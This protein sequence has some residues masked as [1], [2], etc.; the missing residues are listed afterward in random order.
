MDMPL[1]FCYLLSILATSLLIGGSMTEFFLYRLREKYR[2]ANSESDSDG[3]T[4]TEEEEEE[5]YTEKYQE[6]YEALATRELS[7]A[8]LKNL[9]TKIVREEVAAKV[10]VLLTY[11]N[12]TDTFWYYTDKLSEVSYDILETVARKFV[13]DNDCKAIFLTPTEEP[14]KDAP[15]A[16]TADP[17]PS[18]FAKFKSY[19]TGGKGALPNFTS[20]VR[21]VEQ[22]N[23]FRYKG[24]VSD[25]E[26]T[27]KALAQEKTEAPELDY[28]SYKK[29]LEKKEC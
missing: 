13:I 3:E 11:D 28:V 26:A 29:L 21:V 9:R 20:V 23:H 8:E 6:A 27:Q 5:K 25:Y 7:E 16:T 12:S 2:Q 18:V 17:A 14:A 19:N 1:S 22:M 10:E 24:K 15:V 4:D